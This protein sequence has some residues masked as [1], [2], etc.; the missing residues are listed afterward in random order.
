MD[1]FLHFFHTALQIQLLFPIQILSVLRIFYHRQELVLIGR[2]RHLPHLLS[3]Q[4]VVN[5]DDQRIDL[6]C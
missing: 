2:F 5:G 3:G 6:G 1:G 4:P